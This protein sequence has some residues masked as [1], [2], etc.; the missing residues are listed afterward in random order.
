VLK[1]DRINLR[2]VRVGRVVAGDQIEVLAGLE[3]GETVAL[4]PIRAGI[5]LKEKSAER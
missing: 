2:Q 4:D 1:D 5:D 3:A